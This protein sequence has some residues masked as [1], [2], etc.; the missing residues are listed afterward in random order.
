MELEY[1]DY[2]NP[3]KVTTS[4]GLSAMEN[5]CT[6][7]ALLEKIKYTAELMEQLAERRQGK[8]TARLGETGNLF[9][10]VT[11][12]LPVLT[13]TDFQLLSCLEQPVYIQQ[14]SPSGLS[15][16]VTIVLDGVSYPF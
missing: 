8:Y 3:S 14:D 10:T 6:D 11:C 9:L 2:H 5:L 12:P 7:P 16:C 13:A 4:G 15:L 1:A